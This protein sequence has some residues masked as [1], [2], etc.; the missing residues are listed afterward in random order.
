MMH[1]VRRG[2]V[3]VLAAGAGL[4]V[5]AQTPQ[6]TAPWFGLTLPPGLGDP[7]RP[8]VDVVN[9][10]NVLGVTLPPARV[11]PGEER[12]RDLEGARI[13]ED[14]VAIVGFSKESLAAGDRVW[15]RVTG[16][17]AAAATMTWVE[18]QFKDAGLQNVAVQ[19]YNAS[20][21]MWWSRSWE[22]RLLGDARFGAGSRD[23]VLES[24]LPTSGSQMAQ[25]TITAPLVYVGSASAEGLPPI[26]VK[27][28]V[29]VP[30]LRPAAG[31]YSERGRTVQ[32]AQDLMKR[33]AVAVLNVVEQ[34]G[35][36]HVR[37]FGNCGGPC[38]N[39]G[40]ADGA[41]VE[42]AIQKA[43]AA[44]TVGEIRAQLRLQSETLA[45]LTGHNAA[46]VIPGAS[47][48]PGGNAENIIVNAH[49]D[50]WFDASGDNADG[51]AVL[52]AMARHF[53]RPENRLDRTLVFVA[54]GGHHSTGLNG[55]T[56]FVKMN[57]DLTSRT[58]LVLNLEHIAQFQIR[59]ASWRVE[60]TEQPMNFGISPE[61]PL[62]SE[63]ARRGIERYGFNL[64]PAFT[65][66][67]PGDLGGYAPLGVP[68][69]QAIHAGPMY[70]TSG[71]VVETISI[72]GLERAA[73]FFSFFVSE[74][75][76]APRA[77][78]DPQKR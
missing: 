16:F 45:G 21:P 77:G 50:G 30:H 20:A 40:G 52:V 39:L 63:I 37:D 76:K 72:P 31:A 36:M 57:A 67:V 55:P 51:L 1:V 58:I 9:V 68:R 61:S 11:P 66:S 69:V 2:L 7:H 6:F 15:G 49:G 44:R 56:N 35:N 13:R 53:A 54:S 74:A 18:R 41:F 3:L 17:P 12:H 26:D 4:A 70:H 25:G 47:T 78:I 8:V 65:N 23:V 42:A 33:G 14:I 48:A 19:Q 60:P 46:G 75:S 38:F 5:F 62:L 32:R 64:N 29:A 28:K 73:R 10:V 34:T 27:G 59:P 71:D 43:T 24:A 22:V